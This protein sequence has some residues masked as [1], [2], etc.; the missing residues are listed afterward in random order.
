MVGS[1]V[2]VI[3]GVQSEFEGLVVRRIG[4][5]NL[6][7]RVLNYPECRGIIASTPGVST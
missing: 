2:A 6:L 5:G 4:C 7:S 3:S 1:T